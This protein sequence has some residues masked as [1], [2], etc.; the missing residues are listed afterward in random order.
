MGRPEPGSFPM[1]T[2]VSHRCYCYYTT[3]VVASVAF[4]TQVDS[5]EVPEHPLVEH[6]R[7]FFQVSLPRPLLAL[8]C[9]YSPARA[10]RHQPLG[11]GPPVWPPL[12]AHPG[13]P[14]LWAQK[15]AEAPCWPLC[16]LGIHPTRKMSLSPLLR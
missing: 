8:I 7:R 12:T 4:G 6:C 15:A 5:R 13:G 16:L 11:R 14:D 2:P 3:D 1:G 9:K 10:L